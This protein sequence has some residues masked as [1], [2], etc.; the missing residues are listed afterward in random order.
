MGRVRSPAISPRAARVARWSAQKYRPSESSPGPARATSGSPSSLAKGTKSRALDS[1][2][3][4][5]A[6]ATR[7]QR[8][9][10]ESPAGANSRPRNRRPSIS[11]KFLRRALRIAASHD[12]SRRRIRPVNLS[13]GFAR[14]GIRRRRHR[15]RIQHHEIGR[16]RRSASMRQPLGQQSRA[17]AP[18]H[19]RRWRGIR[20]SR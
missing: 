7:V 12:D 19:P 14:L 5:S 18:R 8:R 1:S 17:E 3:I 20:N 13:D 4:P 10:R 16:A 6:R 15:A 11:A 9:W 2:G